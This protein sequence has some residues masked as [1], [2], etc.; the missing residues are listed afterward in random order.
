MAI[1]L[2]EFVAQLDESG[3]FS[4]ADT[5]TFQE[6]QGEASKTAEDLAKLLVKHKKV[7]RLQAKFV[8]Q[9]KGK[10]LLL[11]NYLILDKIGA[12]GMG[13]VYLAEHRRMKRQVAL[14]TLPAAMTKD[15]QS[16]QRFQRE[17]QAAAKLT[18][19]NIVA[20]YDADEAKGVH[21][22]VMEYVEG[23]DLS[24]VVKKKGVLKVDLAVDY[25]LQAAKGLKF[26]HNKGVIHRDIKPANMLL[27]KEG[28]IKIL[29]MGLARIEDE[30]HEIPATQLTQ[31][32]SVMGT[33]DYMA[34]EQ[35]KDTH[36]ADARSDI[37]SLGCSL[38]YLLTGESVYRG[39]TM[40][41][42]IMAHQ[43]DPIPSLTGKHI[44][45]SQDVDAVFQKMVAKKPE[46]RFQSMSEV[47]S[48]IQACGGL[49]SA[50]SSP[51]ISSSSTISSEP[52]D[53]ALAEFLQNQK[54]AS[55]PTVAMTA[56][57]PLV[58]DTQETP[59]SDFLNNTLGGTTFK[60]LPKR[61]KSIGKRGWIAVG[62]VLASLI[63]LAGIVLKVDTAAGTIILEIDQPELAGAVVS[64][65][66]QQKITIKTGE[67]TEPI[68]VVADEKTHTLQ[69]TKGGFETFTKQFTVKAG[70]K[71]T[72]KVRLEPLAVV[73]S[74]PPAKSQYALRFQTSSDRVILPLKHETAGDLTVEAWVTI[75]EDCL[76]PLVYISNGTSL[77]GFIIGLNTIGRNEK[78]WSALVTNNGNRQLRLLQ[79]RSK[80]ESGKRTNI[81]FTYKGNVAQIY[82]NGHK[83]GELNSKGSEIHTDQFITIGN[84]SANIP[85]FKG[86]TDE[87][88]FSNIV[89]YTKDF[90]PKNHFENDKNTLALYHFDEGSGDVL[91]DSSGNGH[92]GKIVDAKWV[93]V[94][95]ELQVVK[96]ATISEK[97][98]TDREVAEWVIGLGGSVAIPKKEFSKIEQL[99]TEPLQITS[100]VLSGPKVKDHDLKRLAG[101]KFLGGLNLA[102]THISDAGLQYLKD[103]KQTKL[104]YLNLNDTKITDK[105]LGYIKNMPNMTNLNAGH[106][107]ITNSGL[108]H[109]KDLKNL[110]R[111][112][113]ETTSISDVG[114]QHLTGL[115]KLETLDLRQTK[116]T[117]QGIANLQKALPNCKIESDFGNKPPPSEKGNYALEFDGKTNYVKLPGIKYEAGQPFTIEGIVNPETVPHK[118]PKK[119]FYQMHGMGK[120]EIDTLSSGHLAFMTSHERGDEHFQAACYSKIAAVPRTPI[121]VAC[122]Y[123]G[124]SLQF[125]ANGVNQNSLVKIR[126]NAGKSISQDYR[127][128]L[129]TVSGVTEGGHL[130]CVDIN[131]NAPSFFHGIIDEVRISNIARYTK[132]FTPTKRF[133]TD[134]NT[135]ALYHFD[136]GSGDVLKDASGNGHDGKIVGAK[137]VTLDSELQVIKPSTTSNTPMTDREVAE[138]VIGIGGEVN[139]SGKS[140]TKI[141][142]FP[143]EPLVITAVS[144]DK[145]SVKDDDLKR[146]AELKKLT[147]VNLADTL[148]TDTGI[149]YLKDIE[150]GYLILNKTK[151]TDQGVGYLKD[152]KSLSVLMIGEVPITNSG[153]E[154]LK[155]M[156]QLT[157][158][159]IS[160]RQIDDSGIEHLAGLTN[161]E[162]IYLYFTQITDNGLK[163]LMGMKKL[164]SLKLGGTGIR[165]AGLRE[166]AKLK[167][168]KDL[169]I[170]G[171]KITD[172]GLEHLKDLKNLQDLG[173][174]LTPISDAGLK[175]LHSMT[176]L[177]T[178]KLSG[179]KV[180]LQGIANLQKAL[181]NC[182]IESDFGTK[183]HPSVNHALQ[184]NGESS[185]VEIKSLTGETYLEQKTGQFTIEFWMTPDL[186]NSSD[187]VSYCVSS[188]PFSVSLNGNNVNTAIYA[189]DEKNAI[190]YGSGS[191]TP[192]TEG[193]MYH[194]ALL[195]SDGVQ[196][197]YINGKKQKPLLYKTQNGSTSKSTEKIALPK[198]VIR[199]KQPTGIGAG[200][201][202]SAKLNYKRFF[203]GIIDEVRISNIARYEK[204]FTPTKRFVPDKHT[205]ALYHFDEAKGDVLKDSSGNGHHGKIVGAKW[206]QVNDEL[207]VVD[208]D[209]LNFFKVVWKLGG[210]VRLWDDTKQLHVEITPQSDIS[211]D[212]VSGPSI[213]FKDLEQFGDEQLIQIASAWNL[214]N[215]DKTFS[216]DLSGTSVSAKGIKYLAGLPLF[217]LVLNRNS[218]IDDK[219]AEHLILLK[220]LDSLSL[221]ETGISDGTIKSIKN[222][223]SLR[224]LN[225]K[226]TAITS[227][228]V[229]H[230]AK[231]NLKYLNVQNTV[232]D[233]IAV[234]KLHNA[235]PKCEITWD[236][237]TIPAKSK[238]ST[239][240]NVPLSSPPKPRENYALQFDG[241][242][243]YAIVADF[244]LPSQ[245]ETDQ[246]TVE[247]LCRIPEPNKVRGDAIDVNNTV[248]LF[249]P[250]FDD[251]RGLWR[252]WTKSEEAPSSIIPFAP[253]KT[254]PKRFVHFAVAWDGKLV[255][256]FADGKR[257]GFGN[258]LVAPLHKRGNKIVL[259]A[260][261]NYLSDQ[262]ISHFFKGSIDEVRISNTARY[263][264]DF[265]PARRFEA[266]KHTMALYHFDEAQ[267]DVLKDSSGNEHDG[268]IV[269]A[270]WVKVDDK[271][272]VKGTPHGARQ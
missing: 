82:V 8:F 130:G 195:F 222:L 116:V 123:D 18:H 40:V 163:H 177:V 96:P 135:M 144:L 134:K 244:D 81:A 16:I 169:D 62:T 78:Q 20:A 152:M 186:P 64:V 137:W 158:L 229:S 31:D 260:I 50:S 199:L 167:S 266:D 150:L 100:V 103:I 66:D 111:L 117:P 41:N 25:I 125:F 19:P 207:Q 91:K 15:T 224:N 184:F 57:K 139:I 35:A 63:L 190:A 239:T 192:L 240:F 216:L 272:K 213:L 236:E 156:K 121:H 9:G 221:Q 59:A 171:C 3:I 231:L 71:E 271:L 44:L 202:L 24:A 74:V 267:G 21:Y 45:I 73:K 52:S 218:K 263:T 98:M 70:G 145:T 270:K 180:T 209:F 217:T 215:T 232:I 251:G 79:S 203:K 248:R 196:E 245:K 179:T 220:Y 234:T 188:F 253:V 39:S 252:L 172:S 17:V 107:T 204:D 187:S 36:T 93:Q 148:I 175:H 159:K 112:T 164:Q 13:D 126:D 10:Q 88:R 138:W 219:I 38:H 208:D 154:S 269:G 42:R 115:S 157:E 34:P 166:L 85:Y 193:R 261:N 6:T 48:A 259:G 174:D 162:T 5:A 247:M 147:R 80:V 122:V 113:L 90:T 136:E 72:I 201:D 182:K 206:V 77:M 2:E 69:V 194:I 86:S 268:K 256:F 105:G 95:D 140:I 108:E 226:R 51:T 118:G 173:L 37:Y 258:P 114:L 265:T 92:D 211:S 32:G 33:V 143:T 262:K 241:K 106:T 133:E 101:L 119:C 43:N 12:G 87:V 89:R 23:I 102:F 97:P 249:C 228:S 68:E 124:K 53:V 181:P 178:L 212:L 56:E 233:K 99:P 161:L 257:S 54:M 153:L 94:D 237:G 250:R 22:F 49:K 109:L 4:A 128:E 30:A 61:K 225:V 160:S 131:A 170:T 141:E 127:G 27:D 242:D 58:D 11:G 47:I 176:N 75:D 165:D 7:T 264:K 110:Q 29:D 191:H 200:H 223:Q 238:N 149:R 26:A 189:G 197:I 76:P 198:D 254:I 151:I 205:M 67:G 235:L 183:Q 129:H 227:N 243:D 142:Q 28:T 230:L 185:F 120:A 84:W 214:L 210:K 104:F 83:K 55:S 132:D 168:L 146:L 246:F 46:D 65:D 155:D 255:R 1:T 14:K 60:P